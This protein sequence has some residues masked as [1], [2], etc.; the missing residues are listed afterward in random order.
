MI[1]EN[2][3][4]TLGSL[5][6]GV[7]LVAAAKTR[8]PEEV[9]EAIEAGITLIGQNYVQEAERAFEAIGHRAKWHMIGHL[10]SN[11]AK[12][13]V[14]IFD[15]IETVD[16]FKLAKTIDKA[17]RNMGTS[18]PVLIEINSG[19]ELQKAGVLPAD[20]M[21]VVRDIVDV[22]SYY[23]LT[24]EVIAASIRHPQHCL[25]AAK[26]GADIATIPYKV[27][28]QMINHPLTD[29]GVTRFLSDWQRVSQR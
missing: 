9:L 23:A 4:E 20:A 21:E 25:A 12:K 16:S 24:T 3:K 29:V 22:F 14:K 1:K 10:Q 19:E 13:A 8:T 7:Q 5:P 6:E 17:C 15:M 2:V 26:A 18:M 11:K 27:L 28:I